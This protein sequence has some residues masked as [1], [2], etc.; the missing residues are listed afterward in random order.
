[1]GYFVEFGLEPNNLDISNERTDAKSSYLSYK[2]LL[3]ACTKE[4]FILPFR[5]TIKDFQ[6]KNFRQ[7]SYYLKSGFIIGVHNRKKILLINE[8]HIYSIDYFLSEYRSYTPYLCSEKFFLSVVESNYKKKNIIISEYNQRFLNSNASAYIFNNFLNRVF[9]S[10]FLVSIIL[11]FHSFGILIYV[12][13][14][15]Y[16]IQTLFKIYIFVSSFFENTSFQ[17]K[18]V[19]YRN[20]PTYTILVPLY[21]EASKV[22]SIVQS[23]ESLNYPKNKL[24]VKLILEEDDWLTI[25]A[26]QLIKFP[27]YFHIIFTP[28]SNPRTKPKACNFAASYAKGEFLV[29]YD[30]EDKPCKNQLID[31]IA[32]FSK[33][34]PEYACLQAKLQIIYKKYDLLGLLF[35]LE[36]D[37]LFSFLLK[38]LCRFNLPVPLGGTSNHFRTSI[39]RKIGL[40]DPYNVTEDA[41]IGL[42]LNVMGYKVAILDSVTNEEASVSIIAWFKQ[43]TRWIKGFIVTIFIYAVRNKNKQTFLQK[44]SVYIFLGL[45][46]LGYLL[47]PI[48]I[49]TAFKHQNNSVI[50][51]FSKVNIGLFLIFFW[52]VAYFIVNIDA[53]YKITRASYFG[54]MLFPFYFLM[55]TIAAYFAVLEVIYKPF[56]WNK[57]DHG[58]YS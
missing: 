10:L 40:W 58:I 43:R 45:S 34:G 35:K 1:M 18:P 50:G 21:R 56:R 44:L 38:G 55:H 23:I 52:S 14:I 11:C 49:I 26:V 25:K 42:R 8:N 39:L 51:V 57:T 31:A 48:L 30:A 6:I 7:I 22:V 28:P 36:Y 16:F 53:N 12:S 13:N 2:N 3:L 5:G 41:D 46:V 17:K 19:I 15:I 54:M 27:D 20:L 47:V 33:L 9:V 37:V 24:D 32:K 29:I 4:K